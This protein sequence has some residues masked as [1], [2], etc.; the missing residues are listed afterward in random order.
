MAKI[1]YIANHGRQDNDDEGSIAH[2]LESLGH[3]VVCVSEHDGECARTAHNQGIDFVLFHKWSDVETLAVTKVP[4]VF[5][6]FDLVR[7]D[8]DP[9]LFT[10]CSGR[11]RWMGS[12]VPHID[13]GFCTDGDWTADDK[14]NKLVLL[15]QG[16]DIRIAGRRG[17]SYHTHPILF[18]GISKGGGI[19]R[20]DF[21]EEMNHVYN[22]NFHHFQNGL[23]REALADEVAR[24]KIVVA[25]DSPVT[26]RYWSNRVYVML[27]FGAFLLHP[28]CAELAKEYSDGKEI[29]FYHSRGDL[30]S[31]IEHYID[32]KHRKERDNIARRGLEKTLVQHTY[33]KRC[34]SMLSTIRGRL[35]IGG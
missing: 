10:R 6:Y 32:D 16:T 1:L 13:L 18:T 35:G 15:R 24:A 12:V 30:H 27:G 31:K 21:A 8:S 14:A 26:D 33:T 9:T 28:Y 3:T 29:V 17:S 34:E 20:V 11:I 5:W 2:A 23:Y 4:K 19:E 25:P 7:Y 22:E